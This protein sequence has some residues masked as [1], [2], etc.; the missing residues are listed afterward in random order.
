MNR[1]KIANDATIGMGAVILKDVQ[2]GE[3]VVGNPGKVI[4]VKSM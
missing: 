2:K 4:K 3:V 1:V